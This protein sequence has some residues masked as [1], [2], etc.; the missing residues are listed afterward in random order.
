MAEGR[1]PMR[2]TIKTDLSKEVFDGFMADLGEEADKYNICVEGHGMMILVKKE[3]GPVDNFGSDRLLTQSLIK[4][5]G[6]AAAV[7]AAPS[8][9]RFRRD[10]IPLTGL[11]YQDAVALGAK[12]HR[13][14]L[15]NE[16]SSPRTS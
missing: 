5:R 12:G 11:T 3:S 8:S 10:T 4:F 15:I 1:Q 9:D 13:L 2:R 6:M 7:E 14:E 16:S